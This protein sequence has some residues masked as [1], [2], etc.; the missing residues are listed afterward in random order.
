ME[1]KVLILGYG[2]TGKA[3]ASSLL[4]LGK[5]SIFMMRN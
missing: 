1:E 2:I 5:K 3:S 4:E